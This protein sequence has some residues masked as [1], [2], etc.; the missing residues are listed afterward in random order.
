MQFSAN[1]I[2]GSLVLSY[3][4]LWSLRHVK[5]FRKM[6]CGDDNCWLT[7]EDYLFSHH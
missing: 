1:I 6:S 7:S 5:S 2:L 4:A 3:D